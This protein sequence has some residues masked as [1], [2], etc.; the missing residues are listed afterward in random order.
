MRVLFLWM[1][2][3]S[4]SHGRAQD[5][6]ANDSVH[7]SHL[8]FGAFQKQART[9]NKPYY[10]LFTAS[11]CAPCHRIKSEVLSNPQIYILSNDNYLAY[12]I[13]LENFDDIATNSKLFHVSQLP[14]ILF[15]DPHG[16]QT[17]KAIGYFDG[18]YFFKKLRAHIPPSRWGSD[19][20]EE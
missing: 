10:I 13:D 14:T 11:W 20:V 2:I 1:V 15:F 4:S 9:Q 3:I 17:D 16:K 12:T 8:S 6:S 5:K 19:W 7:F 18:Y